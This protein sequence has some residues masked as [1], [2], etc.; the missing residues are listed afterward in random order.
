M[1]C[2]A[3]VCSHSVLSYHDFKR[4]GV[5]DGL[6]NATIYSVAQDKHGYIWL[7][8]TNSGLLR[9]DGYTFTEFPL[10]SPAEHQQVG[11]Q[12]VG[13]LLIGRN[14]TLWAGTWGY[15]LS[16]IDGVSGKLHRIVADESSEN[17]LAGMYIQTL[18]EDKDGAVWVGT[19]LGLNKINPDGSI[20]RIGSPTSAQPLIN[21]RIWSLAQTEDGT[22]W[23][24][25]A[26]GLHSYQQSTGLSKAFMLYPD[27]DPQ[28][29][30]NEIRALTTHHNDLWLGGRNALFRLQ[31]GKLQKIPF[32]PQQQTPIINVLRFDADNRLLVGTYNGMFRVDPELLQFVSF[33]EQQSLLPNVNVR[34]IFLD[35]TGVLWL[36]S[37]ESGLYF[38]RHNKSAFSALKNL[39]PTLPAEQFN[40]TVTSVFAA[41]GVIWLGSADHLYRIDR[42]Q[43]QLKRY[44]TGGRVN[45]IRLDQQGQLYA[46]TDV[47]LY[48]YN[49][50]LDAISKVTTP[51]T[52]AKSSDGN[53]RDLQ[54]EHN[55]QFWFGLWG[56]GVL[57]WDPASDKVVSYLKEEMRQ[58]VGDAVQAMLL[59]DK[60]LWVGSR[61]SGLLRI[62]TSTGAVL[63]QGLTGLKLPSD[64][65]QCV[66]P[67]PANAVLLCTSKGL[68]L[69]QP[70]NKTQQ[71]WHSGNGLPSD[72]IVGA[73][74]DR[75]QN[76]WLLS[77]KGLTLRPAG[78]ERF[79]TFTR[80]DGMVATELAFKSIYEDQTGQ[81]LVGTI[82][83]MA[84]IEPDLLWVNDRVPQVAI[85]QVLVNNKS[86][87]AQPH[88]AQWP[89]IKLTPADNSVEFVFASLDYHDVSRNQFMVRLKGF[90][91]DWLLHSGK[92]SAYYSNLPSGEYLFEVRGSNNHG[93]F[94]EENAT[95]RLVVEPPWWQHRPVQGALLFLVL[96]LMLG[97]HQYR[98]R[99]I[100]QINKLLQNSVQ[101]RE[102][103][104]LILETKVTERTKALEDSSLTLSLRTKQ[105]EKSLLEL[106]KTNKELTRL[107]KLKD[108]FISTVSH[109]LRTPL[110]SIRGAVGLI[111]QKVVQPESEPYQLLVQTALNNCERLSNLINDLLDV[112]KFDAGKFVLQRT[113]LDLLD[114]VQQ[115]VTAIKT[116]S[117]KYHVTMLV[118]TEQL[119]DDDFS[120]AKA[121]DSRYLV[122]A[123]PLRIRQV[124]DNLLSN[125]IKFSHPGGQVEVMLSSN[126]RE[127]R[128]AV[129][130]E[131]V[132]IPAAFQHR[133][134]EK[135]SQA[136]ASDSR[137]KEGTGLGLTICKRIIESHEGQIG[138]QSVEQQGATFWFSLPVADKNDSLM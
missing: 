89:L 74:T 96:M 127:V 92:N 53:I 88:T 120:A 42:Q 132:G 90:D 49:S 75:R 36:G 4:I 104:Q 11:N 18:M 78:T 91:K 9:Y 70:D 138:F 43:Q 21:Q 99:H 68:I 44:A 41:N 76:I 56:E 94:S 126:G 28:S 84:L 103:A 54:I 14:N 60:I 106:A 5:D 118:N 73:Y 72:N 55:G 58:K 117:D 125:A 111:A 121:G 38:A 69:Y 113:E 124:L 63:K 37:R 112:Q 32:F 22:V 62:D 57:A 116:Y 23:I 83:G 86:L 30:D 97:F 93:L 109:E 81:L 129:K 123:D 95:V 130:D 137:A 27:A 24:G 8:S 50:K 110:T 64:D 128:V 105:L 133:V 122:M 101:E 3:A 71:H 114:A 135:F 10:L 48:Q 100:R 59:K 17:A 131:G 134:F 35:R 65:V 67:G 61:Y 80:Q 98:L 6:P 39:L 25:T 87:P 33:R 77:A 31:Q 13:V 115:A 19:T 20:I 1:L 34:S 108:E 47:G 52:L 46:A 7:T 136:D 15:G 107:D 12:D 85:S 82:S 66:E 2:W 40:F 119:A 51:F 102:K 29:R 45:S 26:Q 16:R 79:I